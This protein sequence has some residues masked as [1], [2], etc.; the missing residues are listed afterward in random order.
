M[1]VLIRAHEEDARDYWGHAD[2]VLGRN[3]ETTREVYQGQVC[4]LN[5]SCSARGLA[6]DCICSEIPPVPSGKSSRN[7]LS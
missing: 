4:E 1:L 3:T 6:E 2:K 7:V 5:P